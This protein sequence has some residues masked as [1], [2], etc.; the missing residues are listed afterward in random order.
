MDHV[1]FWISHYGYAGLFTLLVF[2][3]VGLPIPDET[4]LMF[5]GYLISQSRLQPVWTFVSAVS[6]SACGISLSYGVG[7]FLGHAVIY[8]Y[9]GYIHLRPEHLE[10][11]HQW[12][13][14]SGELLLAFGYF[15]PAVRHLSALAAGMSGLEY[16]IFALFAYAGAI[17]WVSTFLAIGYIVGD[18]WQVAVEIVRRYTALFIC[19]GAAIVGTLWWMRRQPQRSKSKRLS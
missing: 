14:R 5:S 12:Y 4:L 15:I 13:R 3:I 16:K 6:G 17:V 2:G 7:R 18:H 9:G 19:V 10:R 8:K 1:L 11:V